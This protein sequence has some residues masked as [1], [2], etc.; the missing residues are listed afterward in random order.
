[1]SRLR[2]A[3]KHP[4]HT[5]DDE[6]TFHLPVPL[7]REIRSMREFMGMTHAELATALGVSI[8]STRN[9]ENGNLQIS[10]PMAKKLR[11][12]YDRKMGF[13][14]LDFDKLG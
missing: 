9:W 3:P 8:F 4:Q 12:M 14:T 6:G 7:A 2:A 10:R 11:E 13:D 1:M 5:G